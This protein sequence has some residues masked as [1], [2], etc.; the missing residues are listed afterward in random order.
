MDKNRVY[1]CLPRFK[2]PILAE[3]SG[4]GCLALDVGYGVFT[5][6]WYAKQEGGGRVPY[7]NREHGHAWSWW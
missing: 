6:P 5:G 4:E 7:F 1:V 3:L 2:M